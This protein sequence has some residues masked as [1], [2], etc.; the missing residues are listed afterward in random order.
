MLQEQCFEPS[1]EVFGPRHGAHNSC[2]ALSP[3]VSRLPPTPL[4]LCVSLALLLPGSQGNCQGLLGFRKN[5]AFDRKNKVE[6]FGL[7]SK[8]RVGVILGAATLAFML[9]FNNV[10]I[11]FKSLLIK[12]LDQNS[13]LNGVCVTSS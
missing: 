7:A 8:R 9:T 5:V 1:G 10:C 3:C 12:A 2:S 4:C 6:W 11:R 13:R